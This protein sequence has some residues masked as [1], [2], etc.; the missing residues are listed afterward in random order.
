MRFDEATDDS[1]SQPRSGPSALTGRIA[2]EEPIEHVREIAGRD[3]F[4]RISHVNVS[5]LGGRTSV[6]LD[7]AALRRMAQGVFH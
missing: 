3:A 7:A 4:A 2:P 6:Q 1:E 5:G